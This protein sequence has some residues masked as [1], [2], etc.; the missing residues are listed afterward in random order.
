M[1]DRAQ[2]HVEAKIQWNVAQTPSGD[3]IAYCQPLNL[4]MSGFSLD[5]LYVNIRDALQLLME[6][7]LESGELDKFLYQRGWRRVGD[8]SRNADAKFDVP[9]ELLV[10]SNGDSARALLQ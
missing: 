7:L 8:E 1:S 9:F 2:I 5:D 3:W 6:D 10:K 4:T